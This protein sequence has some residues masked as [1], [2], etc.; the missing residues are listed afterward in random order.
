MVSRVDRWRQ[1]YST[2]SWEVKGL[3]YIPGSGNLL[4]TLTVKT[5]DFQPFFSSTFK[6]D[7]YSDLP[8]IAHALFKNKTSRRQVSFL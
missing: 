2:S 6:S 5:A 8:T 7:G 1:F 4:K 3:D